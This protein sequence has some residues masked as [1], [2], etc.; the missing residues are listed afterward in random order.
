MKNKFN[1][2]QILFIL[3]SC[4]GTLFAEQRIWIKPYEQLNEIRIYYNED[5]NSIL[6]NNFEFKENYL[7]FLS[8]FENGSCI[9]SLPLKNSNIFICFFL[10]ERTGNYFEIGSAFEYEFTIIESDLASKKWVF[11]TPKGEAQLFLIDENGNILENIVFKT[12]FSAEN[13][14]IQKKSDAIYSVSLEILGMKAIY[15]LNLTDKSMDLLSKKI[16]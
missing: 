14:Q 7:N 4:L 16:Y 13:V 3:I 8:F 10:N 15:E 9:G 11:I 2:I 1:C 5:D 6:K 12:D